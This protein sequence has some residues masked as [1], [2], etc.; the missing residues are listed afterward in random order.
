[1]FDDL[2][3]SLKMFMSGRRYLHTSFR[4]EIRGAAGTSFESGRGLAH[5]R[6]T[7][8][9]KAHADSRKEHADMGTDRQLVLKTQFA[10]R[11]YPNYHTA[12][13]R[14]VDGIPVAGPG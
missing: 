9:R 11:V 7:Q 6:A 13:Q 12:R 3:Q 5:H 2:K 10:A 8:A 1:M 4:P 14:G